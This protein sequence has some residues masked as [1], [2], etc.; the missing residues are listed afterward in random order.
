MTKEEKERVR[1]EKIASFFLDLAKLTFAAAVLGGMT[2]LLTKN[3][4]L[5]WATVFVGI[6][7]TIVFA[8]LGN[9]ILKE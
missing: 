1:K 5:D 4:L 9:K 7:V 6:F 8:N 3:T 2:P